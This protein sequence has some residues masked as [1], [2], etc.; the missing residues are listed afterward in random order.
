[1]TT[2]GAVPRNGQHSQDQQQWEPSNYPR[3]IG[4]RQNRDYCLNII[5]YDDNRRP[6]STQPHSYQLSHLMQS[7]QGV[8]GRDNCFS[9]YSQ[10]EERHPL[11]WLDCI[12]FTVNQN[13]CS[14]QT[15]TQGISHNLRLYRKMSDIVL[16]YYLN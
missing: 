5:H 14:N 8:Q 6:G 10:K 7:M 2:G 12:H 3:S 4:T 15:S 16:L 9:I 13:N 11:L 1:M